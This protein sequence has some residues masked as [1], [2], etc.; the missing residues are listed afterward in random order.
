MAKI[1]RSVFGLLLEVSMGLLLRMDR[2][3]SDTSSAPDQTVALQAGD[4]P[5]A[6]ARGKRFPNCKE[7]WPASVR[8]IS[9]SCR[10]RKHRPCQLQNHDNKRTDHQD[11][12]SSVCPKVR[13]RTGEKKVLV[14]C[15]CGPLR[16]SS[17]HQSM[18][19]YPIMAAKLR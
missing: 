6:S 13:G 3:R 19:A 10:P 14:R 16:W 11:C 4:P 15:R 18:V 7:S 17:G 8:G 1:A 9:R 5:R 2:G 12:Q